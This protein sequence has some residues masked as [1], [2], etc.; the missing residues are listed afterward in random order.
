MSEVFVYDAVRTPIGAYRGVLSGTRPDD[1]AAFVLRSLVDRHPDLD[2]ADIDDVVFG[3]ANGAGEENRNVARMA[4]LLAGLPTDVPGVTVNRLCASGMEA[5]I[6]ASRAIAVGDLEVA[7]AGGVESMSRAPWVVEKPSGA[8]PPGHQTMHSTTLGWRMIN[9]EMPDRWTV[10]LGEG[11]EIVA[12]RHGISRQ[13]QDEWALRSQENAARAWADG[14][15]DREIVRPPGVDIERDEALRDSSIEKLAGLRTAFR[16]DGT[17]TAGNASPLS[18]GAAALLLGDERLGERLGIAPMARIAARAATGI[19]PHLFG[20]G[21]VEAAA[22]ALRSAGIGWGE[23]DVVEL[24]EAFA[25]QVLG[26]LDQWRELD[27]SKVNPEGGALALGHPL[28]C[29]GAR[30]VGSLARQLHRNGGGWGV[31]TL[32]V[33]VGQGVAVV[34]EG[35][36]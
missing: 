32:C 6:G 1:L 18:D 26:C 21:P 34:L 9:P 12:D 27:P 3:N 25:A 4:I 20:L 16:D 33:G 14:S 7:V 22:K 24:N 28:G 15:F 11:A 13:R 23:V 8:Y 29:S 30:I 19:E 17:V 5:V 36:P 10:P 35:M 2:P 31:A